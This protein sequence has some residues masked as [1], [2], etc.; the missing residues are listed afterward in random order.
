MEVTLKSSFMHRCQEDAI[1]EEGESEL[2]KLVEILKVL[3]YF[4]KNAAV[5]C[6]ILQQ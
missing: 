4:F 5:L 2:N 6:G 1:D 3:V